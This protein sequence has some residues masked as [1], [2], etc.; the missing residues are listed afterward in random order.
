[1]RQYLNW[2]TYLAVIALFIV[3]AS[4]YYTNQLAG[5]LADEERKK[6]LDLAEALKTLSNPNNTNSQETAFAINIMAKN[7]TIPLI[8]TYENGKIKDN[9]NIDSTGSAKP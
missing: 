6:V 8:T 4:I 9:K 3:G 7:T 2:K 5:K 1:M